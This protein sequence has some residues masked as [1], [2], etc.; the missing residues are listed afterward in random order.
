M[1]PSC[2]EARSGEPFLARRGAVSPSITVAA[3]TP[4]RPFSAHS[5]LFG[6]HI[7]ITVSAGKPSAK[8]KRAD[9]TKGHA[10]THSTRSPKRAVHFRPLAVASITIRNDA[11][12]LIGI[13]GLN[14]STILRHL[15][16]VP[17]TTL[18]N[19]VPVTAA[20][21]L[22]LPFSW[23]RKALRECVEPLRAEHLSN[24][25]PGFSPSL[26]GEF[27]ACSRLK[28]W[29]KGSGRPFMSCICWSFLVGAV[30]IEPTTSPV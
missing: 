15:G 4:R 9:I 20:T 3:T 12:D 17:R 11:A 23:S 26:L 8:S 28:I 29:G 6:R 7:S 10:V 14:C 27:M 18:W 13:V 24:K 16:V 21:P 30:G 25:L 22:G 1:W 2:S 5:S 19:I